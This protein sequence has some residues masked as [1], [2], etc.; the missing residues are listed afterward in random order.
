LAKEKTE[1]QEKYSKE[2]LLNSLKF[3]ENKDL[4][5][6]LLDNEKEYT[7]EEVEGKI[8]GYL[9]GEVK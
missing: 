7:I 9:K 2:R 3:I 5:N 4:L 6:A 1:V 8:K